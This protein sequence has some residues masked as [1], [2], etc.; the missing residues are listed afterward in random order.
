LDDK[1]LHAQAFLFV[2]RGWWR[3]RAA[4]CGAALYVA[5]STCFMWRKDALYVVQGV[6]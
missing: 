6:F 5:R 1:F 4:G 3:A 2:A